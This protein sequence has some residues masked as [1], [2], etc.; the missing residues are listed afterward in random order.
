MTGLKI[1]Q[2]YR[3]IAKVKEIESRITQIKKQI[4]IIE[5]YRKFKPVVDKLD[6]VVFK[7]KYRREHDTAFILFNAAK[8]NMKAYFGKEKL[9]KIK[10]LRAEL[11][12]LYPEKNKLYSTYYSAKEELKEIDVIKKN[13]EQILGRTPE[14]DTTHRQR[15]R[16]RGIGELE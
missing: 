8:Q 10:D 5:D 11:N 16:N 1:T 6:S 13:V 12:E 15:Q 3:M 7:D 2:P 4:E 9:P 14:R